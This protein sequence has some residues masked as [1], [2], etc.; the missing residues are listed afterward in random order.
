MRPPCARGLAL[1][2][3]AAAVLGALPAAAGADGMDLLLSRPTGFAALP[4]AAGDS[5]Q[6]A[7]S[8]DG[9]FVAFTSAGDGLSAADDDTV[10]NV[11]VRDR[12]L[13]TTTLVSR[14]YPAPAEGARVEASQPSISADGRRVAFTGIAVGDTRGKRA[15]RGRVGSYEPV[16]QIYVR[17]LTDQTTTLVSRATGDGAAADF[18]AGD[19]AI[20]ADGRVV[21]FGSAAATLGGDGTTQQIW[22]RQL[23]GARATTLVSRASSAGGAAGTDSSFGPAVDDDGS[24]IAFTTSSNLVAA[25]TNGRYDVYLRD[26]AT[27]TT[28]LVSTASGQPTVEGNADSGTPAL[29]ADGDR[30]AFASR[31]TNLGGD[32]APDTDVFVRLLGGANQ[33]LLASVRPASGTGDAS[34]PR[35]DGTG[36]RV[37]FDV[38]A[39]GGAGHVLLR[40]LST[41]ATTPVAPGE[42]PALSSDGTT[43]AF[44]SFA[45]DLRADDP[46]DFVDVFARASTGTGTP[47]LVSRAAG[48]EPWLGLQNDAEPLSAQAISADGGTVVFASDA[49]GLAGG[50]DDAHRGAFARDIRTGAT[51]LLSPAADIDASAPVISADGRRAAFVA[52]GASPRVYVVDTAIGAAVTVPGAEQAAGDAVALDAVGAHVAFRHAGDDRLVVADLV[53]GTLTPVSPGAIAGDF[54]LSADGRHVAYVV[55]GA[56]SADLY[57]RALPDGV[58]RLMSAPAT[59]S[60]EP[61]LSADGSRVAFGQSGSGAVVRDLAHVEPL[62]QVPDAGPA[63]ISGDGTTVAYSEEDGEAAVVRRLDGGAA[64]VSL[65]AGVEAVALNADG[66][67][68]AFSG[69][70]VSPEAMTTDFAHVYRRD[71]GGT[72]P[73]FSAPSPPPAA[74]PPSAI[75]PAVAAPGRPPVLRD[76][77]AP[78][79]SRV[80]LTRARFRVRGRPPRGTVLRLTLDERSTVRLTIAR[81]RTATR[82]SPTRTLVRTVTLSAGVRKVA[83]SGRTGRRVLTPGRYRLVVQATDRAGNR[84]RPVAITLTVLPA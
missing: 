14:D 77:T 12:T 25:D 72:C 26:A 15:G 69:R 45:A 71:L 65:G 5:D 11:Y 58:P 51:T 38:D 27:A 54:A 78:R 33:T 55:Y 48:D 62:L 9:R 75:P 74:D 64:A 67:C 36:D 56:D 29:D 70:A 81:C 80:T 73:V 61:T 40:R 22:R 34:S 79:L 10:L 50:D 31:A 1:A 59:Y 6:A 41:S 37:A 7:V 49:D 35:L 52:R 4:P 13:R 57:V 44:A 20:S 21:A 63:R 19:P 60:F 16:G 23:D 39:A 8:A 76:R 47:D 53:A 32:G 28:S 84:S 3:A 18:D 68:V 42:R 43:V 2:L 66:R 83:V 30:V 24:R 46:D 17:D 82:C